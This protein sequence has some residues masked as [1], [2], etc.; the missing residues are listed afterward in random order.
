[1]TRFVIDAGVALH[2]ADELDRASTLT[3]EYLALT[4]HH[5]DAFVTLDD[6]LRERVSAVVDTATVAELV[7]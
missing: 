6:D 2:L 7:D 1:M 4:Q 5:A 3:A